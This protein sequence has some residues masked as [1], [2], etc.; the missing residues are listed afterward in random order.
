MKQQR[1]VGLLMLVLAAMCSA[2]S[3]NAQN[4]TAV[5]KLQLSA[6]GG[7]SGVYTGLA[8]GKN[9]SITA[10]VDLGLPPWHNFIRPTLEVRGSYPTDRGDIDA[11]KDILAGIRFDFLLRHRFHPY[12]NALSGRGSMDYGQGYFYDNFDYE[13]TTTNVFSGGGG[14]DFDIGEH[15]A[16]KGDGQFQRWGTAPTPSGGVYAKV[17]TLGLVYRFTFRGLR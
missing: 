4:P 16:V 9:F 12:V 8:G 14:I 15:F 2:R 1:F 5:Q 6:F 7:A 13:R 3:A 11:Q 10:G 17:G